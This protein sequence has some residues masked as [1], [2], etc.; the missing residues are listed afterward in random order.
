VKAP[1]LQP[2]HQHCFQRYNV[3]CVLLYRMRATQQGLSPHTGMTNR[4]T[5]P[6]SR[7]LSQ[8]HI[9]PLPPHFY[10]LLTIVSYHTVTIARLVAMIAQLREVVVPLQISE[11]LL[12]VY[13]CL[14][15]SSPARIYVRLG[16]YSFDDRVSNSNNMASFLSRRKST[17][18]LQQC[19]RI[20][21]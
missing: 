11:P 19:A 16:S 8:P 2:W 7:L 9:N 13:W 10:L 5:Q 4:H 14:R 21:P 17:S 1:L 15:A 6:V 18:K 12:V 20:R 3:Q